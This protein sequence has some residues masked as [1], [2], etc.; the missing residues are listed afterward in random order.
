MFGKQE[1]LKLTKM[2]IKIFIITYLAIFTLA[3]FYFGT[4]G[5]VNSSSVIEINNIPKTEF[6]ATFDS[7]QNK[8]KTFNYNG[9]IFNSMGEVREAQILE[10]I[11]KIYKWI[12]EVSDTTILLVSCCFLGALGSIFKVIKDLFFAIPIG[13][14]QR[15]LYPVLGFVSGFI[16]LTISYALP[17]FLTT[18][19]EIK[20]DPS[21]IMFISILA[22]MLVERFY[23]WLSNIGNG[24]FK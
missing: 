5:I 20:L 21:S 3:S 9:I 11:P 6:T 14:R 10:G 15:F 16:I 8:Y 18:G 7:V 17:K 19:S 22:G 12:F 4:A 23:Q 13:I 24:I 2:L 1:L